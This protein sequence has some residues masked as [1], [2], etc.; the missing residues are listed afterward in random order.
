MSLNDKRKIISNFDIEYIATK[1]IKKAIQE[2]LQYCEHTNIYVEPL[3]IA[4]FKEIF[5]KEL[6]E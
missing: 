5:G 6:V 4:K 3:H 2:F 1:D